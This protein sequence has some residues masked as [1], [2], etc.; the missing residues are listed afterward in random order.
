MDTMELA[1][2]H[3]GRL[4]AIEVDSG[5]WKTAQQEQEHTALR[6]IH[7]ELGGGDFFTTHKPSHSPR[8]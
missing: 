8:Y 4:Q 1:A 7:R 3:H 6:R 5:G 2:V